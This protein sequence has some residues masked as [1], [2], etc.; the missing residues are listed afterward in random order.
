MVN[1]HKSPGL[2]GSGAGRDGRWGTQN[3]GGADARAIATTGTRKFRWHQVLV[4]TLQPP[5]E[6]EI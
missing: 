5:A 6:S 4:L 3:E 2:R 1:L